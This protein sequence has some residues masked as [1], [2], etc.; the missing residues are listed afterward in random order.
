MIDF[1]EGD[2]LRHKATLKTCVVAKKLDRDR[3]LVTTQDGESKSYFVSELEKCKDQP[4]V[5]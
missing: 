3:V 1:Q 4:A 2:V 5:S